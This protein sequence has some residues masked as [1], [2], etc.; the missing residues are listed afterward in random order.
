MSRPAD[1]SH[2]DAYTR[3]LAYLRE[4]GAEFATAYPKV[5]ARLG[6]AGRQFADPHVERLM[7]AFAFLTARLQHQL[8][9]DLPELTTGLLGVLYP[10]YTSPLPSMAIAAFEVD[11]GEAALTSG[12]EVAK[13]TALFAEV[14]GK[15]AWF[16]TAYPVTLWPLRLESA[17]FVPWDDL[18]L[19]EAALPPGPEGPRRRPAGAVRLR[20]SSPVPLDTLGMPRLRFHIAG[21]QVESA[22]VYDLLFERDRAVA[23]R[24]LDSGAPP[25]AATLTPVGFEEDEG[26]LPSPAHAHP[27]HRLVQEY[28]AFP[29]KFLFFD[30]ELG[31]LPPDRRADLL[32]FVDER[33]GKAQIKG[34][35]FK[36]GATPVVNLFSRTA[37]PIRVDQKTHRYRLTGDA[38]RERHTAVHSVEE[39]LATGPGEP[40]PRTFAPFFSFAHRG[41][42]EAEPRVFWYASRTPTGRLDLPGSDVHL[43]FVDLDLDPEAPP[44]EVVYARVLCTNRGL[45][46]EIDAGARLSLEQA[47]P[48]SQ[49]TCLCKP[50]AEV[51]PPAGGQALWRLVSN[52]SLNHLSLGG[53]GG[54]EALREVLRAYLF[55]SSPPAERQI[56]AIASVSS[57]TVSRR[58][59]R[60]LAR[61]TEV[62]VS[63]AEDQLRDGSP[64]L[65]GAV[66]RRFLSLYAHLNS[67]TAGA[68]RSTTR[69]EIWKQWP[70]MAGALP[71]L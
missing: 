6:M 28:F 37:E 26:V 65:F 64:I 29:R 3:E 41:P 16:R 69:E 35:T 20:L 46:E 10:Q 36:L 17:A 67:F 44:S 34:D 71:L 40:V 21:D 39:V 43:T 45:C 62:T 1:P 63:L 58:V 2:F 70:P 15:T 33:P 49:V 5:A 4:R 14:A 57:R 42:E 66:L 55:A 8:D 53:E 11:L 9:Q 27:G 7:E 38:R 47:A 30:V 12:V 68:L 50:T 23:V 59:G 32:I 22:R 31:R 13:G 54:P 19:S 24:G 56:D 18:G 51:E 60:G 52:L 61:G 25:T 48:V